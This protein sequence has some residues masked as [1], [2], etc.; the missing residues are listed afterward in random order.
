MEIID[1]YTLETRKHAERVS[2]YARIYGEDFALIG[3]LHDIIEDT[4]TTLDEIPENI[5]IDIDALTRRKNETYFDYIRRIKKGSCR[6]III[7]YI[8]IYDH[9]KQK[10]TLKPSLKKRY[11][12][13]IKILK[14]I[15]K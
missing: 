3:L 9:L 12:K 13:A 6:A 5:R 1:R 7:K 2:R 4:E 8:D 14:G 10:E 11:E 15:D